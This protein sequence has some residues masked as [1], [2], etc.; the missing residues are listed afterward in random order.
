MKYAH[1]WIPPQTENQKLPWNSLSICIWNKKPSRSVRPGKFGKHC[2]KR[3]FLNTWKE[4]MMY[5]FIAYKSDPIYT[6][7]SCS[8]QEFRGI[9][10]EFFSRPGFVWFV[11]FCYSI[12]HLS[13]SLHISDAKTLYSPPF[14]SSSLPNKWSSCKIEVPRLWICRL[15]SSSGWNAEQCYLIPPHNL[16]VHFR[17]MMKLHK[18]LFVNHYQLDIVTYIK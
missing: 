6:F 5:Q 17:T 1:F 12:S 16:S 9:S 2:S 8:S 15:N 13:L 10:S 18:M 14:Y 3:F 7:L 4:E 11:L